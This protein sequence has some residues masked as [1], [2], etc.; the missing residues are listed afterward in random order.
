MHHKFV[1]IDGERVITGSTNFTNS[2][3]HGD[4][5]AKQTRGNVNHLISIQ[6]PALAAVFK[7]EFAQMWGDGP[8]GSND[9]RFGRNKTTQSLQTVK[10]DSVNISV[11][12]PPHAKTHSGHGLEVIELSLI[13]I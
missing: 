13:H 4:A 3:M 5:G 9:S 10:M 2:G 11:L 1:V 12:F 8:G 7:E 6:S